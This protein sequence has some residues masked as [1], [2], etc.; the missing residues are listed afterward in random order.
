[1]ALD[2]PSELI[3]GAY[4]LERGATLRGIV[5]FPAPVAREL[6]VLFLVDPGATNTCIS[7]TDLAR[8]GAGVAESMNLQPAM[9]MRG[10][11]GFVRI[12]DARRA[13]ILS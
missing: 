3:A 11:G 12:R 9:P 7:L 5:F 6:D 8:L 13:G 10:V 4:N 2:P 1:M